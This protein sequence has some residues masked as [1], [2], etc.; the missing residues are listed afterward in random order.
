MLFHEGFRRA[1]PKPVHLV[2]SKPKNRDIYE[3]LGF[4]VRSF[5]VRLC[6]QLP[7]LPIPFF[8]TVETHTVGVGEV[9]AAGIKASGDAAKGLPEFVMIKV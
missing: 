4:E 8:Q 3:H 5:P 1:S 2:A 7:T 6:F 9:D